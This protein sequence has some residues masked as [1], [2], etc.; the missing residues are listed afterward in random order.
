MTTTI[1]TPVS[2]VKAGAVFI[3]RCTNHGQPARVTHIRKSRRYP[4]FYAVQ[5]V[6]AEATADGAHLFIS[7]SNVKASDVL[8]VLS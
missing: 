1:K 7:E 5:W 8:E 4:G 2:Q 6:N 3:C